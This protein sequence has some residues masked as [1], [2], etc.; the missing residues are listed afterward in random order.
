MNLLHYNG[1][2]YDVPASWEEC[3]PQQVARLALILFSPLPPLHKQIEALLVL[4]DLKH[5]FFLRW[6]F[7]LQVK[8]HHLAEMLPLAE[9]PFA[10]TYQDPRNRFPRI[11]SGWLRP[12]LYGPADGLRNLTF[13]EW[14]K[15]EH[16]YRAWFETY[17]PEPLACLVAVLYRPRKSRKAIASPD[18]NGDLRL[19]YNDASFPRRLRQVQRLPRAVQLAVLLYYMAGRNTII[20]QYPLVFRKTEGEAP[21]THDPYLPL[22]REMAGSPRQQ[23]LESYAHARLHDV[24]ADWELK[25]EKHQQKTPPHAHR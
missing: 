9:W 4:L 12:A 24:L 5:R 23:D 11:R 3:S 16:Y 19:V 17:A 6:R 10:L 7:W 25:I 13:I 22:L 15:A 2:R 1:T 20:Q 21:L 8:A 18:F 14:I